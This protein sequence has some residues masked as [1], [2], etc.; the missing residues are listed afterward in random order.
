MEQVKYL[1]IGG[2]I[3]GTNAAEMIRRLDP[4]GSILIVT[5]EKDLLYSRVMLPD[6]LRDEVPYEK[7]F[8]RKAQD[9][10]K[11]QIGLKLNEPVS[12]V[13]AKEKKITLASGEEIEAEK[14]L[15]ASGGKVN[16]LKNPGSDLAGVSYLRTTEDAQQAKDWLRTSQEA[17]VV[18]GGFIGI[19]FAKT[20]R[21]HNLQT[22]ALIMEKY[23]W[24][25][26]VGEN[27]G[28]LLTELLQENGIEVVAGVQVGQFIGQNRL[29]KVKLNNNQ[30][31]PAQ[32]AGVGIGIHL[33]LDHLQDSGLKINKGVVTD[34]YLQT[35]APDIWAAG[36]IAEFY[37]PIFDKYHTLGNWT[38]SS[39]QGR[40]VGANMVGQKQVFE[41]LSTYSI[42]VF[43]SSFTFLGDPAVDEQTEVV[44]RGSLTDKKLGRILLRNDVVVG[45][46]LIN[47]NHDRAALNKLIKEKTKVATSKEQLKDPKFD[48]LS[49]LNTL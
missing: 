2:G 35:S 45:A 27:S 43:G 32:I 16:K 5:E 42:D 8:L 23:F 11:N 12:K 31:I 48:L 37:D 25:A 19:E 14:I 30:E 40:V 1:I 10:Q 49:L 4:S 21:Q 47:L 7:I 46:S 34:Q 44:E 41:T 20:F 28:K 38:N 3:A 39:A 15:V 29:E 13:N 17:V 6:F 9:Y 26:V 24:E 36:D 18:G 33:D 22:K